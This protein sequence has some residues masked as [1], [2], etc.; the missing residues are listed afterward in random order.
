MALLSMVEVPRLCTSMASW[1]P[2]T[3][4]RELRRRIA[5][6]D[7]DPPLRDSARGQACRAA[8][9]H[10]LHH[11]RVVVRRVEPAAKPASAPVAARAA[12]S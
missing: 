1:G 6:I 7:A 4:A 9:H 12:S 8:Y 11:T 10:E 2:A 3:A 5:A